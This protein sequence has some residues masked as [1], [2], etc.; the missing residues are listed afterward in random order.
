MQSKSAL[1]FEFQPSEDPAKARVGYGSLILYV[2]EKPYW[3]GGSHADPQPF[4]WTW[5]GLLKSLS[6]TWSALVTEETYP[7]DWLPKTPTHP[8][9]IWRQADARWDAMPDSNADDVLIR[10]FERHS[11]GYYGFEGVSFPVL[12]WLR[13]GDQVNLFLEEGEHLVADFQSTLSELER[14]GNELATAFAQSDDSRIKTIVQTWTTQTR[15]Q[16]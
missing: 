7:F 15:I 14:I 8:D 4:E 10:F 13:T 2:N 9:L 3:Y 12:S 16:K 6:K 1:R 11:L 5:I